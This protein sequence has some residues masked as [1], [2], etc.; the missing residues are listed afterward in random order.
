MGEESPCLALTRFFLHACE[1]L[2]SCRM[3]PEAED[4][5]CGERPRERRMAAGGA[6]GAGVFPGRC[7][8]A[9]DQAARGGAILSPREAVALMDVVEQHA[10]KA[11]ANAGHGL[12]QIPGMGVMVLGGFA[13]GECDVAK[14][15]IVIGEER[16]IHCDALGHRRL[17]NA[18]GHAVSVGFVGALC[19]DGR[20]VRL[21][22][23]IVDRGQAFAALA[24]QGHASTPQGPGRAPLSRR[25]LGLR[26]PTAAQQPGDVL[27]VDRVV[28]G[29]AAMD[30]LHGEGMTEDTRDTV[31]SPEVSQPVPGQHACGSQD[32]LSAG[33]GR[34]P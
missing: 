21:A 30:G 33:G 7:L 27:G 29:L 16:A 2:L 14:Q 11:L 18:L 20:E 9:L 32:D 26:E 31:C 12:Q 22:V 3:I 1:A 8:G 5:R 4:G 25:D 24:G 28:F 15:G 6:G 19:A 17:G 34:W 23:G 10:A 13:A